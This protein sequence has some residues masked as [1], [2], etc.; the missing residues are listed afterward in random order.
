[1]K[2]LAI[3]LFLFSTSI[4]AIT[5][6]EAARRGVSEAR[7]MVDII[8]FTFTKL[9]VTSCESIPTSGS[10]SKITVSGRADL[11]GDSNTYELYLDYAPPAKVIPAGFPQAGES[12]DRKFTLYLEGDIGAVVEISCT[13]NAG[14]V[15]QTYLSDELIEIHWNVDTAGHYYAQYKQAS[16][17][18]I[19]IKYEQPTLSAV[20]VTATFLDC[21]HA[22]GTCPWGT[23]DVSSSDFSFDFH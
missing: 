11:F 15:V 8:N 13:H 19:E 9:K 21:D 3:V 22:N 6:E 17:D 12:Y 4:F 5:A 16:A 18:P 10:S 14:V 7:S 20:D 1:M 2:L 23:G